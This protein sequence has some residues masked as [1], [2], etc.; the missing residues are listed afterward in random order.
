VDAIVEGTV[1]QAGARVRITAQ[2]IY[3]AGDEH[4]WAQSYERELGDVLT[5]QGEVAQAIAARI[6]VKLTP[7]E[8]ARLARSRPINP[9]AHAA[10]L[11]GHSELSK[12]TDEGYREAIRYFRQ[13]LAIDPNHALAY[14]G[15]ADAYLLADEPDPE[16]SLREARVAATRALE[17][18]DTLAGPRTALACAS[19]FDW[20]W[21]AA[22]RGFKQ[23]IQAN[24]SYARAHHWYG[25]Y[26]S[27]TGRH[28]EAIAEARRAR[29]LDP[30][31]LVIANAVGFKLSNARRYDQ[32]IEHHRE[33]LRMDPS[34]GRAH[35]GLADAYLQKGMSEV[36]LA[37]FRWVAEHD[38]RPSTLAPLAYAYAVAGHE[39]QARDT[40][41]ELRRVS[42]HTW[43]TYYASFSFARIHAALGE[44]E[45]AFELLEEAYRRKCSTLA[46]L[47]VDPAFDVL[48]AD[49]RFH[50]LVRRLN[51]PD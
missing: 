46:L 37:E 47:K 6:A 27:W 2:L 9:A 43:Q 7:Q 19:L 12:L 33:I 29:E 11:R 14:A 39:A 42:D 24:S 17:L 20:E 21:A 49:P 35:A 36:A 34:F 40:L 26:L 50:D 48:R 16:T 32:A 4:L 15:L 30:L 13:A 41:A 1:L 44:R 22:E 18:D 45:R 51:F 23:A 10:Y 8:A 28:E 3:V 31:S 5:L 38:R 25:N